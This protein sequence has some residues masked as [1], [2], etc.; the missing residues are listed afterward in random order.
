MAIVRA[1]KPLAML[2]IGKKRGYSKA[3]RRSGF[4]GEPWDEALFTKTFK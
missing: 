4:Y 3:L 1:G 2:L